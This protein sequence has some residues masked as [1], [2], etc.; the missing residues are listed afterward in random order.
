MKV[1]KFLASMVLFAGLF[2]ACNKE[3]NDLINSTSDEAATLATMYPNAQNVRWEQ[4]GE[5]RVAEFMNEGVKSEAWFLRSIWQYT[6]IDIPYSALPKAVRAA[7]EASE[8]AKWKIEDI[9]KVERNGTE[10]FYVIEVEKGGQE[11]DLYY[12]PNGKLIKTVKKPHNGSAGQYANPVIPAGVMNTIKAYIASNYPNATILEYEIEDGYIEVDILDGTVHRVLIFTLQGEWVNS[13]VDDGDDDYDYD[14]DAY[15]NNIPANIKALIISYVNQNYPGAVI[16]SI[17]RNSNG[18]YDVEIYYNNREY[19]LLFDAQG[20]FIS[21]NVDDQDD[22]DNIPAHIK[23]KIINY[24]NRNYPG[25]FIK[26]IERKSNGTYKAEIVYN[27]KEYDLLFDAQGNFISGNVDDQDDDDNIPAHIKAK[28]INYINRNYPGAF[29]KDIERKSNGTYKAEIVYNNKE[30]DLLFDAQGNFISGNVDNQDDDDNIPAHIK[31][32]IINYIN[33]NYPGAFIKDI[34]RKSNGTYK[35]EIVYNNTEYDL[36]FNAQGNFVSAHI[37]G[38]ED[39]DDNIPAHIKAKIINYVNRNY[40][41]AIIKDI[42][43]KSNGR[44][45]AEIVYN[46]R[47]YDL[48]FDA[49]GNFISASLDDKK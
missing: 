41:G 7:F 49:Q 11:V 16:H 42:E 47:E 20:N 19:D 36:L 13:H 18:T 32:K 46:N 45:E 9:D 25:A 34:E 21:G 40:P 44:Y 28:I 3:G 31:A 27:N 37:D 35:A 14:D 26:D 23:A 30:Y 17:E 12:M 48:L 10:V 38:Y 1:F 33:R 2:A 4:E 6:E 43:R 15:E 8:Y 29:I 39:D 24:V 22:D 5:F